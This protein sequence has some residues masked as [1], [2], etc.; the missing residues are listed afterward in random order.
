MND[1]KLILKRLG[2]MNI[3][4]NS[5]SD[6]NQ[7]Q[8][9]PAI[10]A[11]LRQ[12]G[13]IHGLDIGAESTAPSNDPITWQEEWERWQLV[14]P[15][16]PNF[17]FTISADTYHPETIFELVKH[18][19]DKKIIQ[20]LYWN[21]VSGQFDH[22][23]KDFLREGKRFQYIYCHNRAPKRELAGKHM[24]YVSKEEGRLEEELRDFF[25]PYIQPKVIFD[26][27]FGFSKT[28][29]ENWV[30]LNHFSRF[31]K[32][33]KHDRWLLGISRK[34]FLRQKYN[35]AMEDKEQLDKVH[36]EV[37]RKVLSKAHGEV[38]VRT[39]RPELL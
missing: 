13:L 17:K 6:G 12:F 19:K 20:D 23:V 4:P 26:L 1:E 3:T 35:L 28:Y 2:V 32:F 22:F 15:M 8:S 29:D 36:G 27:C 25:G 11:R 24:D 21:D 9:P 5:F 30:L 38:W 33:I 7:L 31:Q 16:L 37:M 34:S 14:L 39:H 10:E 18:W